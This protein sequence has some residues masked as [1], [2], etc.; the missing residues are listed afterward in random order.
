M[1]Q[2]SYIV[3]YTSYSIAPGGSRVSEQ[4]S[5]S[6]VTYDLTPRVHQLP[7][8][9]VHCPQLSP[10]QHLTLMIGTRGH[11]RHIYPVQSPAAT[12]EACNTPHA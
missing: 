6:V 3:N 10:T 1:L 11:K 7:L 12:I 2:A 9:H 8:L 4:Y 5:K